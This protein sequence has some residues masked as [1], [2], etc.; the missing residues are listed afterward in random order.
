M[1][2]VLFLPHLI[3]QNSSPKIAYM[4]HL[5]WLWFTQKLVQQLASFSWQWK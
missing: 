5:R 4:M 1:D 2:G 3:L